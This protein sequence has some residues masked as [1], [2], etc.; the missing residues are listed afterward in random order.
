M[1]HFK[2]YNQIKLVCFIKFVIHKINSDIV[3]LTKRES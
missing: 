3:M 2:I 1:Y